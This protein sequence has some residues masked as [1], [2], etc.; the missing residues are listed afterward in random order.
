[1]S[2]PSPLIDAA[3]DALAVLTQARERYQRTEDPADL[4]LIPR[5]DIA[6]I[7]A[8]S[9]AIDA[10][11]ANGRSDDHEAQIRAL[12]N[13]ETIL[14]ARVAD[15]A[16]SDALGSTNHALADYLLDWSTFWD[17]DD[18]DEWLLEPMFAAGRAHAI[19][20][21]AKTG[22]SYAV[23]AACAA[24]A[25]GRSWLGRRTDPVDVLYLDYE[26]TPSDVRD[27]LMEFGY[28]P[29]DDLSKLHYA[30]LPSIPPLDTEEGGK[31]LLWS[32]LCVKAQLVVIDTT[33]RALTGEE[34]SADVIRNYYRH[35]GSKLKYE[36]I[37]VARLDHAGK[38][39]D[40][41]QRGS[42]AKNDDVDVVWAVKRTES[43][44]RWT[45]THR[46]MSWVPERIDIDTVTGDDGV[47][48]FSTPLGT[49]WPAGT[50]EC[51]EDLD[52]LVVDIDVTAREA[53]RI[54]RMHDRGRKTDTIRAAVMWRRQRRDEELL[55]DIRKGA[56]PSSSNDTKSHDRARPDI[57]GRA[58]SERGAGALGARPGARWGAVPKTPENIEGRAA[59]R[60]G[61][62]F[63]QSPRPDSR[64]PVW[65]AVGADQSG[66][67]LEEV[68]IDPPDDPPTEDLSWI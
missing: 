50:K 26:M 32:A 33:G 64:D 51:A 44:Q 48:T 67:D 27:R 31:T 47:T 34:N 63:P 1:M 56:T 49:T 21:G 46:R 15:P 22:K 25:T 45:S 13:G 7:G 18:D 28:G 6:Y 3:S 68:Q 19:F 16:T 57:Q 42:S 55:N 35:T 29:D 11:L 10:H 14:L 5:L 17:A 58:P 30:L 38:D 66:A 41:G 36:G 20:A 62:R 52:E 65:G 53:V 61:A 23:L 4:A 59:G 2:D 8:L 39:A 60:A 37:T 54:L 43:G 40:R 12:P 9:T 24:L